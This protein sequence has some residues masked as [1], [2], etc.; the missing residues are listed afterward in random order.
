MLQRK[1]IDSWQV[2][3]EQLPYPNVQKGMVLSPEKMQQHDPF[4][5]MAEDWFK[6][7]AFSDH[8]HRGFQ[9]ITYVVDGRLEHFD[10]AG[11]HSIL[12]AGDMQYMNAGG[13]ARHAEEAVD[14]DLIHTL[15]LWLNL[16]KDQKFTDTY[17]ENV[18]VDEA[19]TFDID[20]GQVRVYSGDVAGTK[21]PTKSVYPFTMVEVYLKEGAEYELPLDAADT[22]FCYVLAGEASVG[23]DDVALSRAGVAVFE[24]GEEGESTVLLKAKTRTRILVYAGTPIGEPVAAGGPF[25]MNTEDEIQQAFRDYHA[26]KFGP[27]SQPQGR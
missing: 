24:R 8:P 27:T 2:E 20:N 23:T 21:G 16:P 10:N 15:Q 17:Y 25:V 18:R 9:T 3:Y 13:A 11:G 26:G 5:L 19:P 1:T 7:G 4:L 12:D 6:R 14:D 22:A